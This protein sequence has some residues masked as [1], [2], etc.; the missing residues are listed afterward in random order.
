MVGS[1][2]A[3]AKVLP[4]VTANTSDRVCVRAT[5]GHETSAITP[6]RRANQT[7][8]SNVALVAKASLGA[9]TGSDASP[10]APGADVVCAFRPENKVTKDTKMTKKNNPGLRFFPLS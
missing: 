6:P 4:S 7:F 10:G 9:L 8:E 5:R 3:T 2:S 1:S